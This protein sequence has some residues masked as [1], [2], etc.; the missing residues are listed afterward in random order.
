[1]QFMLIFFKILFHLL[2]SANKIK[3]QTETNL[4]AIE[5]TRITVKFN[6]QGCIT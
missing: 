6:V 1:M 5:D 4:I 3:S 2:I